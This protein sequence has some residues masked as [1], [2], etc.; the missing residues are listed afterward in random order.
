[1]QVTTNIARIIQTSKGESIIEQMIIKRYQMGYSQFDVADDIG[2]NTATLSRWE[3]GH[4]EPRISEFLKWCQCLQMP[5]EF[6][7]K[8]V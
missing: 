7:P 2:V 1:M 3:S 5:F 4:S 6:K 8:E